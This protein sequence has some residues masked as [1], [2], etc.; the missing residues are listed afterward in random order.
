MKNKM[1]KI[2]A[3]LLVLA[4]SLTLVASGSGKKDAASTGSRARIFFMIAFL[5][6]FLFLVV[7]DTPIVLSHILIKKSTQFRWFHVFFHDVSV[8]CA[9]VSAQRS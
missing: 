2:L 8:R 7:F 4:L 1:K 5:H 9:Y 6:N 3:L